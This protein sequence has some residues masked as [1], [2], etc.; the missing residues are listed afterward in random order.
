M[1]ETI[2][3]LCRLAG[4]SGAEEPVRQYLAERFPGVRFERA[5]NDEPLFQVL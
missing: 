3:T 1:I 4:P 2:K 5:K